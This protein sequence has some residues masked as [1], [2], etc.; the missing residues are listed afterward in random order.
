MIQAQKVRRLDFKL[1]D[2]EEK[3]LL[4][5]RLARMTGAAADL[6]YQ[7]YVEARTVNQLRGLS[8]L[9]GGTL[10]QKLNRAAICLFSEKLDFIRMLDRLNREGVRREPT[11][12][13]M[14][15]YALA[16]LWSHHCQ[17]GSAMRH[18]GSQSKAQELTQQVTL[19]QSEGLELHVDTAIIVLGVRKFFRNEGEPIDDLMST[20]WE[21]ATQVDS[22]RERMRMQ[23]WYYV[24]FERSPT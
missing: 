12:V 23:G 4:T 15:W 14:K 10:E 16:R 1:G 5:I 9:Q 2:V 7:S 21:L 13:Y 19:L 20:A 18:L 3:A 11:N 24:F 8:S 22:R 6:G 17:T